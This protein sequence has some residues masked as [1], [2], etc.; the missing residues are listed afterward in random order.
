MA[1]IIAT[2]LNNLWTLVAKALGASIPAGFVF[3]VI[4]SSLFPLVIGSVIYFFLVKY[5]S[6]GNAFWV[7]VCITVTL[8]SFF[9]VFDAPQLPDG[10]LLDSTFPLLVGPM[11]AIS[12][13]LALW[14]IP[15]F[16]K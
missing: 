1:G 4:I 6:A 7:G 12:G 14:A 8:V 16:S 3:P 13:F 10:T 2:G 5:V 9:P 11:H 15:K